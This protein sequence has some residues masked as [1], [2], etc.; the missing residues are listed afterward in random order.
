ALD[1]IEDGLV[2]SYMACDRKFDPSVNPSPLA[3]IR[4][5]DGKD[6][7]DG[8]L[9][10]AQIAAVNQIHAPVQFP[11]PLYKGW[12]SLPGWPTGSESSSN[13]KTIPTRPDGNAALGGIFGVIAKDS[14]VTALSINFDAYRQQIQDYSARGDA[15][16]PDLSP[17]QRRGGKL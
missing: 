17:F 1:G 9:S 7:G 13:W 4:C 16:D 15:S 10:D 14:G 12:T 11:F 5:P 3:A 2:S 6:S 8:C